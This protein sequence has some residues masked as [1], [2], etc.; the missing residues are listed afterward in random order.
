MKELFLI[1]FLDLSYV[2]EC[3]CACLVPSAFRRE[4]R[5]LDCLELE[6]GVVVTPAY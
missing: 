1:F 2:Y 4:W 6:L 5:V 3:L